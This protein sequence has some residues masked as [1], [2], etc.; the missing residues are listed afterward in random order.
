MFLTHRRLKVGG[1]QILWMRLMG[2]PLHEQAVADAAQ[3]ANDK[4]GR[5]TANAAAVVVL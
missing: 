1:G 2:T 5:G 4:H 3:Q